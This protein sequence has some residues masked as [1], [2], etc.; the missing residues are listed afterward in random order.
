MSQLL[1]VL[2]GIQG[3]GKSTEAIKWVAQKPYE[4]ARVNRDDIRFTKFGSYV[5]PPSL[6]NA[7][8]K[9]EYAEIEALF[10]S[11]FSVVL[12]NMNL[13]AKYIKPYLL[14]A[15]KYNVVVIHK[16]FPIELKDALARNAARSRV[17]P[18]E[19]IRKTFQNFVRKGSFPP[20]PV[21]PEGPTSGSGVYEPD[22]TKPSAI[23]LDVD[24]TAMK[25]SP[26]R[27]PFE[28]HNV[29]LDTPNLPVIE[30]VIALQNAGHKIVVMSGRDEICKED[31]VLQLTEAGIV[32]DNIFMRP[33]GDQRKDS[34]VKDELFDEHVRYNYNI[35]F[36]LDDRDQVVEHYRDNLGLT[37]F[38]VDYGNF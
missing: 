26:E 2:R 11:G 32:I 18:E 10:K 27:G 1:Y 20:F 25:I 9:I 14:L 3:S 13:R 21:L 37:V 16:D 4:R 33:N 5:L 24:G 23:L 36:A 31:T 19:V 28:W 17:V 34:I 22:V 15:K 30:T 35:L 6:E 7:V 38:Q 29:L 12:D 8:S